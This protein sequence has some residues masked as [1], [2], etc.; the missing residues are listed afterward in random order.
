M[1]KFGRNYRLTI[2]DPQPATITALKGSPPEGKALIIEYPITAQFVVNRTTGSSLNS[3]DIQLLNLNKSSRDRI[4]QDRYS[5]FSQGR[6]DVSRRYCK[7]EAGYGDNLYTIF[8]GNVFEAGSVRRGVDIITHINAVDGGYDTNLSQLFQTFK[9]TSGGAL[10]QKQLIEALTAQFPYLTVG[11]VRDNG[12][13]FNRPVSVSGNIYEQI[14]VYAGNTPVFIDLGKVYVLEQ[15]QVVKDDVITVDASTGL[16][17]TPN[18][19]GNSLDLTTLFEPSV[20]VGRKIQLTST[21]LPEYN[22]AYKVSAIRHQCIMS[23]AV[24]GECRTTLGLII[25]GAPFGKPFEEVE[26]AKSRNQTP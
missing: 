6:G 18:R 24:G 8:E 5:Y 9:G 1:I 7:L 16:L 26:P 15:F 4:F 13:V 21:V 22:G 2:A 20:S 14:K 3:L 19:N 17:E 11:A 25:N 12:I 10:S 23:G